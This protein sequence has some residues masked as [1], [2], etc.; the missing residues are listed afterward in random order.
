MTFDE[1]LSEIQQLES[2]ED[3]SRDEQGICRF[4]VNGSAMVAIEEAADGRGFYL[5][6]VVGIVPAA[7]EKSIS[8]QALSGNLF[9]RETGNAS[10][11]YLPGSNM[12]VLFE[13]ILLEGASA[14]TFKGL[15]AQ[16]LAYLKVWHE[17]LDT[18]PSSEMT[19]QHSLM[20]PRRGGLQIFFA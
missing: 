12:L 5:Y 16:F 6:S 7:R 19:L 8:V 15:L 14:E 18:T 13:Y 20:A 1:L 10:L 3:I 4:I 11:G 17:K 2:V 9:G